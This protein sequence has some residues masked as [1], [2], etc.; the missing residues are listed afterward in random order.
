MA[1]SRKVAFVGLSNRLP[2]LPLFYRIKVMQDAVR[3]VRRI[4]LPRTPVNKCMKAARWEVSRPTTKVCRRDSTE[5]GVYDL[6]IRP[7]RMHDD[8][9]TVATAVGGHISKMS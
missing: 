1:K 7:C 2:A 6:R 8:A 5:E 3:E 4:Y 9:A